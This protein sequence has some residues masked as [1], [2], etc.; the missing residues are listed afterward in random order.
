MNFTDLR[1]EGAVNQKYE[2]SLE[3]VDD[4]EE[5]LEHNAKVNQQSKHPGD[6]K[7]R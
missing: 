7:D 6:T 2:D 1:I 4:D 3:W 5:V